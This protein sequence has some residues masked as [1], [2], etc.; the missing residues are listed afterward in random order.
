MRGSRFLACDADRG[1]SWIG[2]RVAFPQ[3]D[4]DMGLPQ[5]P[6]RITQRFP[7]S[8]HPAELARLVPLAGA[9]PQL[10]PQHHLCD[11]GTLPHQKT[12]P[13]QVLPTTPTTPTA[14]PFLIGNQPGRSRSS[15]CKRWPS[16]P[17][18]SPA[19]Q[20]HPAWGTLGLPPGPELMLHPT[21]SYVPG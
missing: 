21:A 5:S 20:C 17:P 2:A 14:Q 1:T 6:P 4:L 9:P 16:H 12:H 15:V 7:P 10:P 3:I 13:D 18:Q 11:E 8:P 19:H